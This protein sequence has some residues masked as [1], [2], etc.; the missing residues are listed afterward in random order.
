MYLSPLIS[1]VV[2]GIAF[3]IQ[4]LQVKSAFLVCITHTKKK[5]DK[6]ME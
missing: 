6:M 1:L 4:E 3:K 5:S 2:G